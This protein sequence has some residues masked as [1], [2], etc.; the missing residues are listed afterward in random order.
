MNRRLLYLFAF[1]AWFPFLHGMQAPGGQHRKT[2]KLGTF[3]FYRKYKG[4]TIAWL[5]SRK[6]RDSVL[7]NLGKNP[8][9][10]NNDSIYSTTHFKYVAPA[11]PCTVLPEGL[12]FWWSESKTPWL[13]RPTPFRAGRRPKWGAWRPEDSSVYSAQ[14]G[15]KGNIYFMYDSNARQWQWPDTGHTLKQTGFVISKHPF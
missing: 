13:G 2:H 7:I 1:L 11:A 5:Y 4:D 6:A 14:K 10:K 3:K 12:F 9:I 8:G 15:K